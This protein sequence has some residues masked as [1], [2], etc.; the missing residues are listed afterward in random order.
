MNEVFAKICGFCG[1]RMKS[2]SV[3]PENCALIRQIYTILYTLSNTTNRSCLNFKMP[4]TLV[5]DSRGEH[6]VE[7]RFK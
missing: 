6:T 2:Q 5:I 7:L 4:S 3:G 1:L